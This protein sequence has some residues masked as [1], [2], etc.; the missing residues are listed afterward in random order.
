MVS[1][2][3]QRT[4]LYSLALAAL[5]YIAMSV[6]SNTD[7]L[8]DAFSR[9][10]WQYIPLIFALSLVNYCVRFANWQF[11]L[12][13]IGL[14]TIPRGD[15]FRIFLSGFAMSISPGK[16]GELL[17]P[18]LLKEMHGVPL[19][20]TASIV[21]VDR[22]TDLIALLIMAGVGSMA[23]GYGSRVLLILSLIIVGVLAC[24]TVRPIAEY[25]LLLLERI[26]GVRG[27]ADK[28]RS[29]YESSY[30][31]LIPRRLMIIVGISLTA[32]SS[33]AVGFFLTFQALGLTPSIFAA[34]FIYAF[35]TIL[36]AVS[37]L[38]GGLGFTEATMAGLLVLISVSRADA[39]AA[40]IVIRIATLWFA[41]VIGA[42]SL[43]RVQNTLGHPL[44]HIEE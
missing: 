43:I 27:K 37:L 19:S 9:I 28:L 32:W 2:K 21:F 23:F 16:I 31:L 34:F 12:S 1:P 13:R 18:Y 7:A 6:W 44:P 40:T 15:S 3:N 22:L 25:I 5:V 38:P 39:T 42:I 20:R 4:V 17:R 29:L 41:V 26:P 24:I 33:E 8:D 36:G 11:Y 14:T 30:A 10:H 35:S